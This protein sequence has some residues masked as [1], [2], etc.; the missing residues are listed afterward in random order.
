MAKNWYIIHTYSGF[1]RKVAETLK[2]RVEPAGL[3]EKFG[4]IMVPTE[5]VIEMRQ[6]KKVVTPKLFYPGY[7]LVEMEMD[8]DTWHLVTSTPRVTGFVG[9]GQMP[10]PLT[11]E[12]VDRIVHR[13]EVAAEHPKPKLEFERGESVKITDGPFKDFTGQ[14]DEVNDDRSTLRVMVTIFGRATPVELDF[15]QVEKA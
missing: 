8:N 3:S 7:V 2:S 15:Y 4:A 12:E 5:D 14:V 13:V 9:S 11:S 6:G 1:E 10:S